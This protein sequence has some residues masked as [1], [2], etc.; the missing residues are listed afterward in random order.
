MERD[1]RTCAV[2]GGL[3]GSCVRP[4]SWFILA[5]TMAAISWRSSSW[6]SPI[7]CMDE[8]TTYSQ[9]QSS[10]NTGRSQA[11]VCDVLIHCVLT[12]NSF[13]SSTALSLIMKQ[14]AKNCSLSIIGVMI[15][16]ITAVSRSI[17]TQLQG[18]HSSSV[19]IFW[20]ICDLMPEIQDM[21]LTLK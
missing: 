16:H 9:S 11:A 7:S 6:W 10:V 2:L 12:E 5:R 13:H 19:I 8:P 14:S 4:E 18:L 17:R 3:W 1:D 15:F 20:D 21:D